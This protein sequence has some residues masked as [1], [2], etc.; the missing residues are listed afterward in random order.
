M[1]NETVAEKRQFKQKPTMVR[2]TMID[3]QA[4]FDSFTIVNPETGK[5]ETRRGAE[6]VR[7][8]GRT[9]EVTST[10]ADAM[11]AAGQCF[12]STGAPDAVSV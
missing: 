6:F 8:P 3:C 1:S 2:V 5:K 11:I 10:E 7:L 12:L 9:Y 4:G